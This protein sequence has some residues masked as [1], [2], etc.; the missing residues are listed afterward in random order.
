MHAKVQFSYNSLNPLFAWHVMNA[1]KNNGAK[2][3][4]WLKH[5]R[6]NSCCQI[7]LLNPPLIFISKVLSSLLLKKKK[8][9]D[10]MVIVDWPFSKQSLS[11]TG[12]CIYDDTSP[13]EP[14][15]CF[16]R[17][18]TAGLCWDHPR[19]FHR[20]VLCW[21]MIHLIHCKRYNSHKQ[22]EECML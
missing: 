6:L 4:W 8:K 9:K 2:K 18:R 7:L 15:I 10:K 17:L 12:S 19:V 21:R 5:D 3:Q 14:R 16:P 13:V 22:L 1:Q 11:M 20:H